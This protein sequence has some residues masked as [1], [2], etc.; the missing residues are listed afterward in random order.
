MSPLG[1]LTYTFVVNDPSL[2]NQFDTND[3]TTSDAFCLKRWDVELYDGDLNSNQ[4]M[5]NNEFSA[6]SNSAAAANYMFFK[7]SN[8]DLKVNWNTLK[9]IG[10][11]DSKIY[12]LRTRTYF[13]AALT[14]EKFMFVNVKLLADCSIETVTSSA[15]PDYTYTTKSSALQTN[16]PAFLSSRPS[17]CK[18]EYSLTYQDPQTLSFA[19]LTPVA[20]FFT[21]NN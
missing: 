17:V 16:I 20:S 12:N 7:S 5:D 1:N 18:V 6:I 3:F 14:A 8:E 4:I 2:T 15:I 19:A 9:P 21:W 13:D 10:N 11:S